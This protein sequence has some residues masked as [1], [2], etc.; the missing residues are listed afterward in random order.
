MA[1]ATKRGKTWTAYYEK[2]HDAAGKRVQGTK[3]GFR[4]KKAPASTLPA[5][6]V[7]IGA[8]DYAQAQERALADGTFVEAVKLSVSGYLEQWLR[9][10]AKPR[11]RF[12][13]HEGYAGRIKRYIAPTIGHVELQRLR[14]DAI[15]SLYGELMAGWTD[16][17]GVNKPIS[18]RTVL[19]AHRVL[20]GTLSWAV[21]WGLLA[22]NPAD[23]VAPPTP[24]RTEIKVPTPDALKSLLAVIEGTKIAPVVQLAIYTGL[25]RSEVMGLRWADVDMNDGSLY[26]R[27]GLQRHRGIGMVAEAPK[28]ERSRRKVS[29][30]AESV[31]GLRQHRAAQNER[32]LELGQVWQDN[33]LVFPGP[34]GRPMNP[35]RLSVNFA[36]AT[37]RAGLAGM[38][39]HYC[40]HLHASYLLA[41]GVHAKIV[42]ERL[43]HAGIGITLDTYSHVLPGLQ[44]Q[45]AAAFDGVMERAGLI[46]VR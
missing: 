40:R 28:T 8:L 25:R 27:Q 16:G 34:D 38:R 29:L 3:G 39:L 35:E 22:R 4:V 26:V 11:L 9:D 42:S 1:T 30:S 46:G 37:K 44:D 36:T 19:G 5:E 23:A 41:A 15:Q 7:K 21:K 10:Y 31:A 18:A 6:A 32:R 17:R 2:G 24:K 12:R 13:T 33:D 43:G 20:K 45:A 14:P